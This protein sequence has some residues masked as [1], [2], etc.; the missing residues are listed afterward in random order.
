MHPRHTASNADRQP[1]TRRSTVP[2]ADRPTRDVGKSGVPARWPVAITVGMV[3]V[4]HPHRLHERVDR[5]RNRR[6]SSPAWHPAGP[7]AP[8]PAPTTDAPPASKTS[9]RCGCAAFRAASAFDARIAQPAERLTEQR[10]QLLQRQQRRTSPTTP[11]MPRPPA[12]S[13]RH[14]RSRRYTNH[15]AALSPHRPPPRRTSR[16]PQP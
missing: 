2:V 9:R 3:I 6:T 15:R 4:D 14:C 5:S 7:A 10:L 16:R 1:V 13:G 12:G 11:S 8:D